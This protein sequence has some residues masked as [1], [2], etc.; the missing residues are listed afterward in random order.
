[1]GP[2]SR[3][4]WFPVVRLAA[5]FGAVVMAGNILLQ[6]TLGSAEADSDPD[7]DCRTDTIGRCKRRLEKRIKAIERLFFGSSS[8]AVQDSGAIL[9]VDPELEP[10][11]DSGPVTGGVLPASIAAPDPPTLLFARQ[12]VLEPLAL[13]LPVERR[14]LEL[15]LT[16]D[17]VELFLRS[18]AADPLADVG[19]LFLR[20]PEALLDGTLRLA[21]GLFPRS[22]TYSVQGE[23]SG[24]VASRIFDFQAGS[25]EG[26]IFSE[27]GSAWIEREQ[28]YFSRFGDSAYDTMGLENGTEQ[29]DA[30]GLLRD[31]GKVLWDAA[32]KTYLSKYKFRGA[33]RVQN[34]AFYINEWR[35]ADF[36]V[37]P[38]LVVG[39]L[40][41]RGLEKR[42]SMGDTW[43]RISVEPLSK[44]VTG[45]ADM[46]AG[47]SVEWGIKGL[48]VGLILSAGKYGGRSELDFVGIG[49]TV[50]MV[51]KMLGIQIGNAPA[52]T[53]GNSW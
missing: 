9:L 41:W 12:V 20:G 47:V 44:W 2:R 30:R 45:K 53:A 16:P 14:S 29:V 10:A 18:G 43:V 3:R 11:Q 28:R 6:G 15:S 37:L 26:R 25:R 48:P 32:R 8:A 40:W 36:A 27:F 46:V 51:R 17:L 13:Q 21:C 19:D 4:F 50:G 39:Y 35:G 34:D 31:Q 42:I 5:F 24:G 7:P 38:P 1:M 52:R 49:T 22:D 23:S 33:E